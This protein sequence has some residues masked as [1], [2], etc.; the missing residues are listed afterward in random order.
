M[1]AKRSSKT[2]LYMSAPHK[3]L[4]I[5]FVSELDTR[6]GSQLLPCTLPPDVQYYQNESG[7]NHASP[8][9]RSGLS[10]SP[11]HFIL[12]SWLHCELPTG[13]ALNITSLSSYLNPTTNAPNFLLKLIQSS[14]TSLVLI[15]DLP[16][17]KDL[18]LHHD[19]LQ[20]FIKTPNWTH[21]GRSLRNLLRLNPTSLPRYTSEA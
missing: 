1:G 7:A 3:D 8:H 10:S 6:L 13:G 15:L 14:P 16:P 2:F 21:L 5:E 17:R 4:M 12:G 11:I 18:V 9:I 19:Y 20:T